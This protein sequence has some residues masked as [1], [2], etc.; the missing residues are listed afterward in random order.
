MINTNS[1]K[2]KIYNIN[3]VIPQPK[4]FLNITMKKINITIETL[5]TTV[6][7]VMTQLKL[8]LSDVSTPGFPGFL[9]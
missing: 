7:I 5:I 2:N 9:K 6:N 8:Y 4:L 3:Q 1:A